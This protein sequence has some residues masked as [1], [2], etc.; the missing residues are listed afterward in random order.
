MLVCACCGP[1]LSPESWGGAR[2]A[3]SPTSVHDALHYASNASSL[4]NKFWF[5]STAPALNGYEDILSPPLLMK[6]DF[7]YWVNYFLREH[8]LE[9][10]EDQAAKTTVQQELE[11]VDVNQA[12]KTTLQGGS[13][14]Q[15]QMDANQE[16]DI[17]TLQMNAQDHRQIVDDTQSQ[18]PPIVCVNTAEEASS[19]NSRACWCTGNLGVAVMGDCLTKND[20]LCVSVG[21]ND[22]AL[23]PFLLTAVNLLLSTT[24]RTRHRSSTFRNVRCAR[25]KN[26]FR[27]CGSRRAFR[28]R[29]TET[30]TG[31]SEGRDFAIETRRRWRSKWKEMSL[32]GTN[33]IDEGTELVKK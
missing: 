27:L 32:G 2:C 9:K 5:S 19:L 28:T 10:L 6:Q 14:E 4:D 25:W 16:R 24:Y 33:D 26:E 7:S 3:G 8:H 30:C 13:E 22:I 20:I 1:L 15:L 31:F 29:S 23:A 17:N 18:Q 11:V 21:G 12:A